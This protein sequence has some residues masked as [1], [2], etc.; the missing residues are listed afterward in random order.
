VP[1]DIPISLLNTETD[2]VA[3]GQ[4][5]P[6]GE[7]LWS[8]P[9]DVAMADDE[10]MEIIHQGP[11]DIDTPD[12]KTPGSQF[13]IK[14]TPKEIGGMVE[15]PFEADV[16]REKAEELEEEI[17]DA[18][19]EILAPLFNK[20]ALGL[21]DIPSSNIG[22]EVLEFKIPQNP[23]L[24]RDL[25]D[26]EETDYFGTDSD[27]VDLPP[28]NNKHQESINN[29]FIEF[30]F[31]EEH[32]AFASQLIELNQALVS[33]GMTKGASNLKSMIK[34]ISSDTQ[35]GEKILRQRGDIMID[36]LKKLKETLNKSG[37][38]GQATRIDSL[39]TE[40]DIAYDGRRGPSQ[41]SMNMTPKTPYRVPSLKEVLKPYQEPVS[42]IS[43]DPAE[44]VTKRTTV[45]VVDDQ[46]AKYK[47]H[48]DGSLEL[49]DDTYNSPKIPEKYRSPRGTT[50]GP[51]TTA[52][53]GMIKKLYSD[54]KNKEKMDQLGV[55]PSVAA[56]PARPAQTR[57][58]PPEAATAKS[59][60]VIDN[61]GAKYEVRADGTI[62]V[63]DDTYKD[64][65]S[66]KGTVYGPEHKNNAAMMKVFYA[67]EANKAGLDSL[68]GEGAKVAPDTPKEKKPLS[69]ADTKEE[70]TAS[71]QNISLSGEKQRRIFEHF[72]GQGRS[73]EEARVLLKDK[74]NP[75][76]ENMMAT[77][78][79][80]LK[81][82]LVA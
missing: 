26:D 34:T 70:E 79:Y 71:T 37:K 28:E 63:A 14:V 66:P 13:H 81:V 23:G 22:G 29:E 31:K 52:Y 58:A 59:I 16:D 78:P 9:N 2:D 69:D 55:T 80:F 20:E 10:K 54:P 73:S 19:E 24:K 50:W 18:L 82:S 48:Q 64:S 72:I 38:D 67:Q 75:N 46:N 61:L 77:A 1:G 39:I 21:L 3:S 60:T 12:C 17:H 53:P 47:L 4:H 40:A 43:A 25:G 57:A 15:L 56:A 36:D 30:L 76:A 45:T 35:H 74:I 27:V 62:V 33:L 8:V 11:D 44:P 65:G 32:D 51:E 5:M 49:L 6:A 68:F 41:K 42:G 7:M